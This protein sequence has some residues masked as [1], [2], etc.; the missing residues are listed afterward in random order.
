VAT[1]SG[2]RRRAGPTTPVISPSP[3]LAHGTR[4]VG[5]SYHASHLRGGTVTR[6][7]DSTVRAN[8]LP[9]AA[10][11]V[12]DGVI[13]RG[14]SNRPR[15]LRTLRPIPRHHRDYRAATTTDLC[16]ACDRPGGNRTPKPNGGNTVTRTLT[17]LMLTLHMT[18]VRSIS[19]SAR[20]RWMAGKRPATRATRVRREGDLVGIILLWYAP[21]GRHVGAVSPHASVGVI[22]GAKPGIIV[23][24]TRRLRT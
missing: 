12:T 24:W 6:L 3:P 7:Y 5:P 10:G 14:A 9:T 2:R 16:A 17:L 21:T 1:T 19:A 13:A 11:N 18:I 22:D 15:T 20:V 23:L 8:S 4:L